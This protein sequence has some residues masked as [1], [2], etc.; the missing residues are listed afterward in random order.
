MEREQVLEI[1]KKAEVLLEGHFKLTSGRHSKNYL[2]CAKLFQ[3][4]EYS[5]LMAKDMAINF[6]N[7][8]LDYVVGPAIGG[9]VWSYELARQI[10]VK[11]IFAERENG[12]MCFRRGFSI[13]EGDRVIIAEDVITTGGSVKE[14]IDKVLEAKGIVVGVATVVNR[15]KS[16]YLFDYPI[17]SMI[18]F[19]IETYEE[20]DCPLCK[21]DIPCIK[22]GSRSF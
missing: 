11:N 20:N 12:E 17:K 5:E 18:S 3:Y 13:K 19:N 6:K 2:Q 8:K 4:P 22:P 14:V 7:E 9:I 16:E 15:S 21:T 1:L 10:G